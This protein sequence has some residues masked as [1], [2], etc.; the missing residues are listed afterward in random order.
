MFLQAVSCFERQVQSRK[1]VRWEYLELKIASMTRGFFF[2]CLSP[3][4]QKYAKCHRCLKQINDF[5]IL[6][7]S[8]V[9]LM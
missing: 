3:P 7:F 1:I 8:L 5:L 4:A 9:F 6:L 2:P